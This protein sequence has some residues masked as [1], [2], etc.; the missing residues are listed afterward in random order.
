MHVISALA[1]VAMVALSAIP[2]DASAPTQRHSQPAVSTVSDKP[3]LARGGCGSKGGPG[4]RKAN[5]KCAGWRG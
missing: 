5:G 1:A 4:Y 2:C 3:H